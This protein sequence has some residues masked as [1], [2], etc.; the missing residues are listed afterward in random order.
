MSMQIQVYNDSTLFLGGFR[1]RLSRF[2]HWCL[3]WFFVLVPFSITANVSDKKITVMMS[4]LKQLQLIWAA[5]DTPLPSYTAFAIRG[6]DDKWYFSEAHLLQH[7]DF[8]EEE[9]NPIGQTVL[10][11][12]VALTFVD[13]GVFGGFKAND[14]GQLYILTSAG[15]FRLTANVDNTVFP[16]VQSDIPVLG[17]VY[18]VTFVT[19]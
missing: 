5:A 10:T 12:S 7:T 2:K 3:K 13:S 17:S 4:I 14:V 1:T 9:T 8:T 16:D 18:D 15:D 11:P 6:P 19:D